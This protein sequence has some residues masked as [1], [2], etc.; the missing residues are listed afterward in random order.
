MPMKRHVAWT[1][2]YLAASALCLIA[3][4]HLRAQTANAPVATDAEDDQPV[5]LS[6]FVV[7]ASEDQGYQ[8][9]STLAGT[10]VRTELRDVAS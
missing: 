4:P 7:E 1:R 10:R 8:A 2:A 5:V 9:K 3:A 6:P